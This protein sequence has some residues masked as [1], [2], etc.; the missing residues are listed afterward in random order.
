MRSTGS[1]YAGFLGY[2]YDS[3]ATVSN[4]W[5]SGTVWGTGGTVGSFV[6]Y[7]RSGTIA[8][9]CAVAASANGGR[10][11]NGG[12]VDQAGATLTDY[13]VAQRS[14]RWPK[15]KPR[16]RSATPISTAAELAS[17]T[18]GDIY[19]LTADIDLGG[20][21]W[22]PLFQ[23][24][25]FTGEFYGRNY[26]ISNFTVNATTQ[27]AGLFGQISG[28]RVEGVRAFGTVRST[29]GYVGGF[30]GKIGS[31]SHV[32]G[33]SFVGEVESSSTRVGGFVGGVSEYPTIHRCC[34]VGSVKKTGSTSSGYVGGF[35]GELGGGPVADSYARGTVNADGS[36]Y[37]GGFAGNIGGNA[38]V[39]TT[40][41]SAPVTTTST[42]YVGAFG[43]YVYSDNIVT[44][45]HYEAGNGNRLA[46]GQYNSSAAY[47]GIDSVASADMTK[48]T[49]FPAFDFKET[50][51]IE[52]EEGSATY[53]YLKCLYEFTI[54]SF[55]RWA[56]LRAGLTGNPKP[57]DVVNG[58]PLAAR[59]IFDIYSMDA[60]LTE[61]G[62]PVMRVEFDENGEP[63]VQFAEH[64]YGTAD[65]VTLEVLATPDVTDWDDP[66]VIPVDL[67][68]G[69]AKPAYLNGVPP[70]MFFK[71]RM[72]I[73]E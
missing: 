29:S 14:A 12:N 63:Y 70:A 43:G 42:Y 48:K 71:W 16:W 1:N 24:S 52:D 53:P 2:Q 54:D 31:Y 32:K 18:N 35:V 28:G 60:V 27:Y 66:E 30:A 23:S 69:R 37:T 57:E 59:Y 40:Y 61:A 34:A 39:F 15:V 3:S 21:A 7:H 8:T 20:A 11:F 9:N 73:A 51:L 22:T 46:R 72:T 36:G 58:I 49:S 6:G 47:V 68:E 4:C 64:V 65:E 33:C 41:C 67:D 38:R 10:A 62:D 56:R 19:G 50:W 44:N 45:S 55:E 5:S 26:C 17:I 25:G 13:A